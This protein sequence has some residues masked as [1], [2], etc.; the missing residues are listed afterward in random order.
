MGHFK[1]I[2]DFAATT[3]QPKGASLTRQLNSA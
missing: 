1:P 2:T 3:V